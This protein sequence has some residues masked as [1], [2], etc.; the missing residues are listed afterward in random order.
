MPFLPNRFYPVLVIVEGCSGY[1]E[2]GRDIF[3]DDYDQESISA[4]AQNKSTGKKKK[5][6]VSDNAGRGKLHVMLSNMPSKK[7]EVSV[8]YRRSSKTTILI[9]IRVH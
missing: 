4:A 9:L 1:V 8:S 2:D 5:K 6:N 7:K 3:D